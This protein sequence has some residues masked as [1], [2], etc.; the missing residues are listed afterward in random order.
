MTNQ[1][2]KEQAIKEAYQKLEHWPYIDSNPKAKEQCLTN[3]GRVFKSYLPASVDL[4][5]YDIMYGGMVVVPKS[6]RHIDDN[7]SWTRIE[8]DGSN[9]PT[10]S[11]VKYKIGSMYFDGI[12]DQD[13]GIYSHDVVKHTGCTHYKP[14]K[15]EPKPIY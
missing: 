13:S 8:P 3:S 7:H 15:E 2:A 10:D 14:I 1:E 6:I 11:T 12:F 9:L 4:S 5:E